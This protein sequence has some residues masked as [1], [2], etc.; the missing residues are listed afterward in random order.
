MFKI[1]WGRFILLILITTVKLDRTNYLAWFQL[2]KI[3][4]ISK[5]KWEYV[6]GEIPVLDPTDSGFSKWRA[7]ND[8]VMVW[9]L[10]SMQPSIS[11]TYLFW[12]T[13]K[14]IWDGDLL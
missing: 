14:E 6:T 12:G 13:A 5:G 2:A 7:E 9:L 10:H 11:N 3:S 8:L 1:R 4:L